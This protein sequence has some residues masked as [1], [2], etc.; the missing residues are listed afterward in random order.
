MTDN[1]QY[2]AP[3]KAPPRPIPDEATWQMLI[4]A[5]KKTKK[6][7][8]NDDINLFKALA[9]HRSGFKIPFEVRQVP[10]KGRGLFAT[11]YVA[12]A[13]CVCDDRSGKFR[14]EKEWREFLALL[15]HEVAKDSVDWCGVDDYG[16]GE[17]VFLDFCELALLNHGFSKGSLK[18]WEKKFPFLSHRKA[19][20]NLKGKEF[21]GMWH[22]VA[23]RDIQAGEEL[24]CDY[25]QCGIG[26]DHNLPWYD[27]IYEEYYPGQKHD[28][29]LE[30]WSKG[31]T[32]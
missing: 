31:N 19:T 2:T 15:P 27:T 20:A 1:A 24:L 8:D 32:C 23:S 5:Y 7:T 11:E 12:K 17:A 26:Y 9:S 16:E 29:E 25:N 6:N 13:T 18:L 3:P 4:E 21:D 10:G 30:R 28:D 14:T 22:M